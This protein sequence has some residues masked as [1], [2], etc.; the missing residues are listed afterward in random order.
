MKYVLTC[1]ALFAT[2]ALADLDVR[3]LEGAPKDRFVLTF[4][5]D[6]PLPAQQ[7]TIDLNRSAGALIFDTT[8]NGAGVEVFQPF[9]LVDGEEFI[10]TPPRVADG[11]RKI[12]LNLAPVAP[13]QTVAFTIDVDDT[14]SNRQITVNG[15]E[16]AGARVTVANASASFDGRAKASV[17][18]PDCMG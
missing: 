5:S 15:S 6:C 11:D 14:V 17:P 8:G 3:F 7:V 9:E 18:L 12:T 4:N 10:T 1:L 13:G 16:I 2:P